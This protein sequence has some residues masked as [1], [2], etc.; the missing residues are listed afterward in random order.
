MGL[1]RKVPC[2][3]QSHSYTPFPLNYWLSGHLFNGFSNLNVFPDE[4]RI[5]LWIHLIFSAPAERYLFHS[6]SGS[7]SKF[8]HPHSV[9]I[10]KLPLKG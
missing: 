1:S 6:F 2:S 9:G 5:A 8:V 7:L 4:A 3:R 10:V